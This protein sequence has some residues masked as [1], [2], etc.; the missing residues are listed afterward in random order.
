[1]SDSKMTR[2]DALLTVAA[3]VIGL[4]GIPASLDAL[5]SMRDRAA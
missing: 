5:Q 3:T 2:R 4:A 1:M